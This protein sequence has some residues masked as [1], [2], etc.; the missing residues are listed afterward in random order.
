VWQRPVDAASR[1]WLSRAQA[2]HRWCLCAARWQ[3]AFEAGAAPRVV[4]AAT[5]EATLA[6]VR[7]ADLKRH[8]LDLA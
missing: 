6:I 7:I 1:V 8:G 3:E 4:L 5:H 2:G